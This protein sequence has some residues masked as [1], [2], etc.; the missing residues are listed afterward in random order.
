MMYVLFQEIL[1]KDADST[2]DSFFSDGRGIMSIIF[3]G[4]GAATMGGLS[5]TISLK[6]ISRRDEVSYDTMESETDS[7]K[8]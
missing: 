5:I 3:F 8:A 2:N 4:F 7:T 1:L 6:A